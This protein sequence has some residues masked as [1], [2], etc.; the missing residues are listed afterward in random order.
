M[1]DARA[2]REAL[3]GLPIDV[4][5]L[6][7]PDPRVPLATSVRA[8]ARALDEGLARSVGLSNVTRFQLEEALRITPIA[9]VEV[10]L[11]ASDDASARDGLV[12]FCAERGIEVFAHTPL[13]GPWRAAKLASD[14]ALAPLAAELGVSA[15]ELVLAYLV[16]LHPNVIP[17][18][19]A[20][21]HA[22]ATSLG[23]AARLELDPAT[24]ARLDKRF[25]GLASLRGPALRLPKEARAEVVILM[26]I[27][28]AG[29]SRAAAS[30]VARGYERLNRDETGGTLRGIARKL[31]ERL[32]AGAERIVLDNTY[33]TR[34]SR[35]EVLFAASR[36]GAKV[37]CQHFEVPAHEAQINVVL[38][39]LE[40][41][42][43]LL[44]PDAMARLARTTPN[45][46][47]PRVQFRML[48]E[49]EPPSL[50]EGFA[51]VAVVP[52][53]R[54]PRPHAAR[55][56]QRR[57]ARG[58]RRGDRGRAPAAPRRRRGDRRARSGRALRLARLAPRSGRRVACAL[59][60]PRPGDRRAHGGLGRARALRPRRRAAR[61]L[62]PASVARPLAGVRRAARPRPEAECLRRRRARARDDGARAR[63]PARHFT[64]HMCCGEHITA[65]FGH[66]LTAHVRFC[67]RS[68]SPDPQ[69]PQAGEWQSV[70]VLQGNGGMA[71]PCSSGIC[72]GG[73]PARVDAKIMATSLD[74]EV[75]MSGSSVR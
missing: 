2:S 11:G 12:R 47:A 10:A 25:P 43:E 56:R 73:Q 13:G 29:K 45:L 49:L 3:G 37:V 20:R 50:D 67:C 44:E 75:R 5:L 68:T 62:V 22:T 15:A 24:L 4:L 54:A 64:T 46:V 42:G 51:E 57:G 30:F 71:S 17:L 60:R 23:T 1:A 74:R 9:A 72:A 61:L 59:P 41:F 53:E 48:R 33:V 40:Q 34:A 19:G 38:R 32:A 39:M 65:T 8:L 18:A 7:A 69:G 26:G 36:H 35:S 66:G 6:H 70:S 16:A 31:E 55:P 21:R 58:D 14:R 28:G 63:A 52:F 27:P